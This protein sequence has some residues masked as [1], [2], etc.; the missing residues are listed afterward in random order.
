MRIKRTDAGWTDRPSS[1]VVVVVV[2]VTTADDDGRFW[3]SL[4]TH[5][6]HNRKRQ[7]FANVRSAAI[8]HEWVTTRMSVHHRVQMLLRRK[9]DSD[10]DGKR[11]AAHKGPLECH[12]C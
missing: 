10:D 12:C 2:M 7:H 9:M 6:L 1:R 8:I 4:G 11:A 5:I 3:Q